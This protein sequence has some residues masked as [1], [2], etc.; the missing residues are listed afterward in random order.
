VWR[1]ELGGPEATIG[2]ALEGE[3]PV[4]GWKQ[5][6]EGGLLIWTDAVWAGEQDPGTAYLLYDDG[7]WEGMAARLP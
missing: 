7:T 3:R 1:E 5:R 6:F 2:W 4:S